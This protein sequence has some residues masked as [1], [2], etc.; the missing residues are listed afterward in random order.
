MIAKKRELGAVTAL[1]ISGT[2]FELVTFRLT[3]CLSSYLCGRTAFSSQGRRCVH[4][5]RSGSLAALR[6]RRVPPSF[7]PISREYPA[8]SAA[9]MAANLRSTRP[10]AKAVLPNRVG[11][12]AHRLSARI[13]TVIARARMRFS[14]GE[15]SPFSWN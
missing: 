5:F 6:R 12:L 11:R 9:R 7:A 14:A 8:T 10:V 13:L 2:T 1:R 4:Q 3:V 15:L